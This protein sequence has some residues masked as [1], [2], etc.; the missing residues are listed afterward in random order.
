MQQSFKRTLGSLEPLF[1]FIGDFA[2][3][4][5]LGEDAVFA[6]NLAIEELFTNM[7]KYGGGAGEV[8]VDLSVCER[9][10]VILMVHAGADDFDPT[11]AGD[12]DADQPLSE[13]TP[14]GIG[15]HLVRKVMD[16]VTYEHRD[17][18][19]YLRLSKHLGGR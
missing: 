18:A 8:S 9:D 15:L 17:G 16:S 2:G 6:V 5:R 11:E 14:G 10:L 19:A 7:V 12:M 4:E 1:E 3:R 13:R